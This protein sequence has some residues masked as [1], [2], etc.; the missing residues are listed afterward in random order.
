MDV[1]EK[2]AMI[3]KSWLNGSLQYLPNSDGT[4]ETVGYYKD[5]AVW[6][7]CSVLNGNVHGIVRIW[8]P[9]GKLAEEGHYRDGI[10]HGLSQRWYRDG[11]M[12]NEHHLQKGLVHGV[13]KKWFPSGVLSFQSICT[14]G[15]L[16]GPC[17]EWYP[18]GTLGTRSHYVDGHRDGILERF[19]PDGKLVAKEMYVRG[20]RM[21]PKKYEQFLAGQLPAK[22]ILAIRNSEVRRILIEDIGYARILAQ[23]LHEVIDRDGEQ[24]LVRIV[25]RVREEPICLVKVKCPSTG[26]YYTLRVPPSMK[27]VKEAVAWTFNVPA[28]DYVPENET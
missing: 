7:R 6:F 2:E 15:R 28:G 21:P 17:L 13:Q 22:D 12:E 18:N 5:G 19:N 14:N 10:A 4:G 3:G 1:T 25:W 16:N 9:D 26:A 20:V 27:T 8:Y 23:M 24:E 11:V